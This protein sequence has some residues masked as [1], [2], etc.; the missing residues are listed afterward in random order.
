MSVSRASGNAISVQV[1][2][3]AMR[4]TTA[5][6]NAKRAVHSQERASAIW[7]R[8]VI[9]RSMD[10]VSDSGNPEVSDTVSGIISKAAIAHTRAPTAANRMAR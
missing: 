4:D 3:R 8:A 9:K 5:Q 6:I 1:H 7:S 2:R 10:S